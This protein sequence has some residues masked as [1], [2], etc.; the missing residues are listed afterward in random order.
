MKVNKEI[1]LEASKIADKKGILAIQ[2]MITQYE[3]AIHFENY[4]VASMM[5]LAIRKFICNNK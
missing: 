2:Y 5:E 1:I 3:K 4:E